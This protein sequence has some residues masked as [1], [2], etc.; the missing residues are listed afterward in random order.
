[1]ANDSSAKTTMKNTK[2][3]MLGMLEVVCACLI[4]G[5]FSV[6]VSDIFEIH[7]HGNQNQ[8]DR[9]KPP[10]RPPTPPAGP[11]G[12]V[13]VPPVNGSAHQIMKRSPPQNYSDHPSGDYEDNFKLYMVFE[14]IWCS[15][16]IIAAGVIGML[17]GCIGKPT[18]G[19]LSFYL[20]VA[21][22]ILSLVCICVAGVGAVQ[23]EYDYYKEWQQCMNIRLS[24]QCNTDFMAMNKVMIRMRSVE[25]F[26]A[27]II[28]IISIWIFTLERAKQ[29]MINRKQRPK[30]AANVPLQARA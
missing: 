24:G 1:M 26:L 3:I 25:A 16:I 28:L 11:V 14:G 4:I 27:A 8:P 2:L 6:G 13:T 15:L 7:S 18:V 12:P 17:S 9:P 23:A 5:A 10:T 19:K 30:G 21:S 22:C 29:A 20:N